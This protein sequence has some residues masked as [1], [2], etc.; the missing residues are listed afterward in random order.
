MINVKTVVSS[1]VGIAG[2][3]HMENF[4]MNGNGLR[5]DLN[6]G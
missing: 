6:S 2:K 1:K 5:L 3:T 4:W